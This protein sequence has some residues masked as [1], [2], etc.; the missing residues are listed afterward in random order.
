MKT[1]LLGVLL[2]AVV[3]AVPSFAGDQL[4]VRLVEV[5]Y[6]D[7][8]QKTDAGLEDV[9]GI[10]KRNLASAHYRLADSCVVALPVNETLTLGEY[11]LKCSGTEK[12]LSVTVLRFGK[13]VLRTAKVPVQGRKPFII[14]GLPGKTGLMMLVFLAK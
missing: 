11:T 12:D 13:Q 14:G 6:S 5:K 3:L 8:D 4:S 2:M 10:L 7:A 1:M 9:I